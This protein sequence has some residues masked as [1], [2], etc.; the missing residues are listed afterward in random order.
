MNKEHKTYTAEY[1]IA[2]IEEYLKSEVNERRFA[3]EKGLPL[4]T[5]RSWLE[6]TNKARNASNN[7]LTLLDVT[8]QLTK[9]MNV[10]T[11]EKKNIVLSING[12]KV[13]VDSQDL[14]YL[15]RCM[16]GVNA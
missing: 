9:A 15:L 2:V 1:K 4:S 16:G 5:L 10:V 13:E 14:P 7:N 11:V 12:F 8:E 6:K 3:K